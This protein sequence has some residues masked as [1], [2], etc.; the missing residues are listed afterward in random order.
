MNELDYINIF[1]QDAAS[2]EDMQDESV[3]YSCTN[4]D[5]VAYFQVNYAEQ[6]GVVTLGESVGV[7]REVKYTVAQNKEKEMKQPCETGIINRIKRI[8]G[9][10]TMNREEMETALIESGVDEALLENTTDEQLAWMHEHAQK[11]DPAPEADQVPEADPAP[12]G[13]PA[14]DPGDPVPVT[15]ADTLIDG[16]RLGD[17]AKFVKDRNAEVASEHKGLVDSL[18]ANTRCIISKESL[19][20][21]PSTALKELVANFEP[22]NYAGLGMPRTNDSQE[23]PAPPKIVTKVG[24]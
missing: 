1:E 8:L 6:D 3:T 10:N 17:I 24:E 2:I 22:G 21:M 18:V 20:L 4:D 11:A 13:D 14:P 23:I 7:E 15:N 16:V 19:Q 12:E 5:D 9:V